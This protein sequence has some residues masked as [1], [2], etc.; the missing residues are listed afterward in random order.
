MIE[1][2]TKNNFDDVLPLIRAYQ[3]FYRAAEISEEK[4]KNHF[5]RFLTD[6]SRGFLFLL[7]EEGVS[8]GFVTVYF[9]YSS[10]RA[11]EIGILND[12]YVVPEYRNLGY[13]KKLIYRAMEEVKN[14]GIYRIQWLTE[15]T[16]V[17]A[18]KLYDKMNAGKSEWILYSR[19]I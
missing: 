4:N 1:F 19:E 7:K 13:G 14:R 11:E 15:K 10:A 12:L 5:G 16:N 18:Q 6:H 9:S 3:E 2:I 17:T 8:I